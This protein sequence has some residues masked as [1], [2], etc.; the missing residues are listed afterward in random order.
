MSGA[1]K[2]P[3]KQW[4]STFSAY[5]GGQIRPPHEETIGIQSATAAS[6]VRAQ[7]MRN[8]GWQTHKFLCVSLAQYE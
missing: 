4:L 1:V 3:K 7:Y 6:Y 5:C 8:M 2:K